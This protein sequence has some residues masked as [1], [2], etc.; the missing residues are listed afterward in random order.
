MPTLVLHMT[1][2][3][4]YMSD[5][6]PCRKSVKGIGGVS[7]DVT[8]SG[9]LEVV[10]VSCDGQ[11]SVE[12]QNVLYCPNLGYNLFS[13]NAEF[14]GESWDHLGGPDRVLTAFD[15][16]VIFQNYDGMLVSPAYR[17]ENG[18][19][20]GSVLAALAPSY[21]PKAV[22]MDVNE[23]H[24]IY[25][26]AN[27]ALLRTTAKRL[28]VELTNEMQPCTGCSMSQAFRKGIARETKSR[29]DKKL[30]RVF[31]DLERAEGCSFHRG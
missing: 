26:H 25:A 12:L 3:L 22:T 6:K 9:T 28:D 1:D 8:L 5:I 4:D 24:N 27:E 31:V 2:S 16:Q 17:L 29:S 30:G 18:D 14:D 20:M 11:F 13:P 7:C 19:C 10:F 23:C 21:P 15:G